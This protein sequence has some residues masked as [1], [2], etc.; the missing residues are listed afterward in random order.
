MSGPRRPGGREASRRPGR[1]TGAAPQGAAER[2]AIIARFRSK[3]HD[4]GPEVRLSSAEGCNVHDASVFLEL[5]SARIDHAGDDRV[6]LTGEVRY[7]DSR[8]EAIWYEVPAALERD[9]SATGNPWLVALLPLAAKLGEELRISLP[10]DR[11]LVRNLTELMRI[12]RGW[13][14]DLH[15]VP[16]DVSI[17]DAP[18]FRPA[19]SP[20]RTAAF[21]SGGVDS[22]Y[23]VLR[24]DECV[25]GRLPIDDLISVQ[26]FDFPLAVGDAFHRH[27]HRLERAGRE[28]GK[29][30]VWV[31][32]NLKESR[33]REAPWADLWHGSA[34]AS[35]GLALEKRYRHLLIA[36][37]SVYEEAEP[38]GSHPLT[39]PLHSTGATQ[40]LHDGADA[41]R[42]E[43]TVRVARS[44]VALS[45]LHVCYR[46]HQS[47]NCGRCRKCSLTMATLAA[48][49]VLERCPTFP[50]SLDLER[51]GRVY[52]PSPMQ[53]RG[54]RR[55]RNLAERH[56]RA[57]LVRAID[58]A[59]A[60]SAVR[61][62]LIAAVRLALPFWRL[63]P[64]AKRLKRAILS[65][66]IQ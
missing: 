31:A 19:H 12:W 29:S 20:V 22:F 28:L 25:P 59:V 21:F 30:V 61:A 33:L 65:G 16:L 57:D 5:T 37:S 50:Q 62:R 44:D 46:E 24:H 8:R 38:L 64:V 27:L 48:L 43:K 63:S 13:Y 11:L 49:G 40:V 9:L 18:V 10:V 51:I 56:R 66:A 26:G 45:A 55:L 4:P 15:E 2:G 6:R 32:T 34:L 7:A 54:A 36:A 35:V 58:R 1:H 47:E 52:L 42:T 23:T 14:P 53:R 17:C 60:A 39:D 3:N 41:T